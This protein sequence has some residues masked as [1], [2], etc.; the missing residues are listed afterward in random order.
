V[1]PGYGSVWLCVEPFNI[2]AVRS[3]EKAGFRRL[4]GT[5]WSPEIEMEALTPYSHDNCLYSARPGTDPNPLIPRALEALMIRSL[6]KM[7]AYNKAP[8]TT[9]AVMHPKQ[10]MRLR[11]F[12]K[13]LMHSTATRVAAIGAA[14]LALP[15]GLW[16][17]RRRNG[18]ND[19]H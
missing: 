4:P 15:L 5:L 16:I 1:T 10:A 17:G 2:S 6:A 12:R 19:V 9:F 13:D 18:G 8:R 11:K 3:Y 14:A 7:V